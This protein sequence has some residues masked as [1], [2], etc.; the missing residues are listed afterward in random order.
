[1]A[2]L[3]ARDKRVKAL[4]RR[5]SQWGWSRHS[6]RTFPSQRPLRA[7]NGLRF[8]SVFCLNFAICSTAAVEG[9]DVVVGSRFSRHSVFLTILLQNR[10]KSGLSFA[11]AAAAFAEVS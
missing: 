3:A 8:C 6:A 2:D 7:D 5:S 1:M 4:Y 11:G 10:G 9:Y